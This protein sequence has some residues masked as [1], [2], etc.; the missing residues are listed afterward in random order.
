ML[1]FSSVFREG[2]E[3]VLFLQ[4]LQLESGT[5]DRARGRDAWGCSGRAAVGALT[6]ALERRLPYKRMLVV[7]GVLIALVLVVLVGNT[8]RTLQGVGWL[9]ITPIDVEFPL[10]MGTWLGVFPTVRDARR[11]R[12]AAFAFVI[13]S[14]F[15]AEW[16]PQ[17]PPARA[18]PASCTNARKCPW[19]WW[20]RRTRSRRRPTRSRIASWPRAWHDHG[21]EQRA[22]ADARRAP[23]PLRHRRRHGH[24]PGIGPRSRSAT[25]TSARSASRRAMRRHQRGA[26]RRRGQAADPAGLLGGWRQRAGRHPAHRALPQRVPLPG[27]RV[28][29][30]AAVARTIEI[31]PSLRGRLRP[32][33][34]G[35]RLLPRPGGKRR[36]A[37]P[38]PPVRG[39][40][41]R[42]ARAGSGCSP[43]PLDLA[44]LLSEAVHDGLPARCDI[45]HIHLQTAD[46]EA[47]AAFW[48]D[49]FGLDE[50][51][52]FGPQAVFL[53][54]GL[55]H[56][57]IGA[58][59]WHSA[60]ATAG[61]A[62]PA[63]ARLVRAAAPLVRAGRRRGG[64]ARGRRGR[65]RGRRTTASRSG[66]RTR[67]G[68]S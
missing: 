45:G 7:T 9:S 55:Y 21:R 56:H 15:A 46:V 34:L 39:V 32:R 49:A 2:F 57:H 10:W 16:V 36:R 61:A 62:G 11:P 28:R 37:L 67:T 68:S 8:M 12:S 52:R 60:G 53:A 29:L 24:A 4:A 17:A 38:R 51:Q 6:F 44:A 26:R 40:A 25:S 1:G 64:A 22:R 66:T 14:Y 18:R 5:G 19:R 31:A 47:T 3:T 59:T 30:A 63:G 48:R 23:A 20:L 42:R 27:P 50:R 33:G 43:R 41:G 58:N 13:G 65:G 35:R 54:E